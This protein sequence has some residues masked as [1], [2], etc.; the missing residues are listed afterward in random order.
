MGGCSSTARVLCVTGR[1]DGAENPKLLASAVDAPDVSAA[2]D[3]PVELTLAPLQCTPDVIG[4][5]KTLL[6]G[7]PGL[8]PVHLRLVTGG[9]RGDRATTLRLDDVYRVTRGSDLYAELKSLLGV[10]AVA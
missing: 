8:V 9:E 7:H 3:A 1:F 2:G 6:A 10:G 4:R 5:L